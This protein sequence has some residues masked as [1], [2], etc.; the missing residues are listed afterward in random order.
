MCTQSDLLKDH[1]MSLRRVLKPGTKRLNWNSLGVQDYVCRCEQAITKFESLVNQVQKNAGDI[2]ERLHLI[3]TVK[4]FKTPPTKPG[5]D[6]P[7]AKV[8]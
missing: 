5:C 7:E 1:S 4:L 6:V 3:E 8:R 2:E